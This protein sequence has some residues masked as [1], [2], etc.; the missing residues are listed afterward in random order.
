MQIVAALERRADVSKLRYGI[1]KRSAR[2]FSTKLDLLKT[3]PNRRKF[4]F[5]ELKPATPSRYREYW[6]MFRQACCR[7]KYWIRGSP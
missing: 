7:R 2:V 3:L 4:I 6:T 5:V 1:S